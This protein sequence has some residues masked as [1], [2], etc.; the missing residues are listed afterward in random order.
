MKT[1]AGKKAFYLLVAGQTISLL[2]SG[3]TRFALMIWAYR[4][5]GSA[6]ALVL[7]G[8]FSYITYILASP[9]AGVLIDRLNRKW[10]MFTADLLSGMVTA[11]LLV[12]YTQGQM[13]L[14]HLYV[15]EGLSGMFEAFQSPSFFSAMS[16]L[17]P[18]DEYTRSNALVG[19]TKSA[20]QIAAPA[21]A[22]VILSFSDLSTV[23]IIDLTTLIFGLTSLLFVHLSTPAQSEEGK[24]AKGDFWHEIRFGFRYIFSRPGLKGIL[25]IFAGI[26]LAAGLT[27][28]SILSPMILTRSNGNQMTLGIVQTIM[29]IGGISG[30]L[31]LALWKSPRK[32]A[33]LYV[34]STMLSFMICDF[35]TA[36]SKSIWGWSI[37]GF[38]SE[39][40]IPF[41]VSPYYSLWQEQVP[42]DVQGRVFATREMVQMIPTP[43]GFICGGLLADHL[44]DPLFQQ[45][46]TLS[47]LVGSGPGAGMSAMFLM[48]GLMGTLTGLLGILSPAIR[49]LDDKTSVAENALRL[50]ENEPV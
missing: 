27:Y 11:A 36:A 31:I 30:G 50:G 44:F 17:M 4:T 40:T 29:G 8:F 33:R 32:K 43:I 49:K 34:W 35:C 42:P 7:L 46:N 15:A 28:M 26:N 9:I 5:D 19:I 10:I 1:F 3:L 21:L 16:L 20:V 41:M 2:G 12:L 25:L 38:F 47:W 48:T 6:T 22:S 39:L 37:S 23:M 45:P 18:K 14:W 24:L 13:Q